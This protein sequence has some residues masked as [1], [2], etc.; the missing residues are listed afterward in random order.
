MKERIY[1]ITAAIARTNWPMTFEVFET[2]FAVFLHHEI[3]IQL[4][5]VWCSVL[6]FLSVYAIARTLNFSH[7][8][9]FFAALLYIYTP[10]VSL[11]ATSCDTDLPVAGVFLLCVAFLLNFLQHGSRKKLQPGNLLLIMVMAFCYGVGAK[12]LMGF[13]IPGLVLLGLVAL[14]KQ[15]L[16]REFLRLF[17]PQRI[18]FTP[19]FLITLFLIIASGLLGLYWYIRN[20][21]VF[22]NPFHPVDFSIF[23]HLIFGTGNPRELFGS[24]QQGHASLSVMWLNLRTFL[25]DKIFDH[26]SQMHTDI[27]QMSGWGWFSFACGLPALSFVLLCVKRFRLLSVAFFLSFLSLLACVEPDPWYMRFALWFPAI[28]A[29]SFVALLQ[30]LTSKLF[31]IPII[32]LSVFC[33][34]LNFIAM[35]NVGMF[36]ISDFQKMMSMPALERSTA[37]FVRRHNS[38]EALAHIPKGETIAYWVSNNDWIYPLYDSDFS[39]SLIFVPMKDMESI[40]TMKQHNLKY[41]FVGPGGKNQNEL[42]QKAIQRGVLEEITTFLYALK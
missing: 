36:N 16:V 21:V 37:N 30:I 7:R 18:H 25:T 15:Q 1:T 26:H 38:G 32:A 11:R 13:I 9:S 3:L 10:V 31:K 40:T 34:M 41:L 14:I 8:L 12:P 33:I 29:L 6:A 27:S 20:W 42:I 5:G 28:F 19:Y 2:W 35:L 39:R 24:T 22:D 17:L 4:A 23:G